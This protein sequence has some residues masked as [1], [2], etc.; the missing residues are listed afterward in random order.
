M[1]KSS[2]VLMTLVSM[3]LFGLSVAT[4]ASAQSQEEL[5]KKLANPIASLISFPLQQNFDINFKASHGFK[6]TLNIQPVIPFALNGSWNLISRTILPVASQ[7]NVMTAGSVQ[8]GLGDTVQSF[9]FSPSRPTKGGITWGAGP[10]FLLPTAT[11]DS[12]GGG[13]WGIGPTIVILKQSGPWTFGLLANHL[14]SFAGDA[15]RSDVSTTF[16]QPFVSRVYKGG[17]SWSVN[18]ENSQNW[19]ADA[20]SGSLNVS[21][22]QVVPVFGQLTQISIGPKIFYGNA[23]VR[24]QWGFR[25]SLVF[26]FPKK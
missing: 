10:V 21:A 23:S 16:F 18:T 22:A 5:A 1:R 12:L 4:P 3:A 19:T 7:Y 25:V 20:F 9:F 11:N 8:T 17:F 24:P 15:E 26:L 13:K 2:F 6:Y 14:W